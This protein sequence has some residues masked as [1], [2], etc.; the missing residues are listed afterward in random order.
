MTTTILREDPPT[1]A[2]GDVSPAVVDLARVAVGPVVEGLFREGG[3]GRDCLDRCV[4]VVAA[5]VLM[6]P[7]LLD[8]GVLSR[9]R[10]V[11]FATACRNHASENVCY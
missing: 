5:D 7:G 6:V 9:E 8:N 2:A 11:E 3:V 1:I 4:A 10:I